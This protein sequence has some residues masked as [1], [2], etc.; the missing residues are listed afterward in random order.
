MSQTY[1]KAQ[2]V[3][4]AL[5]VAV[6]LGPFFT[7]AIAGS[8]LG[9]SA[10]RVHSSVQMLITARLAT[11]NTREGIHV[12]KSRLLDLVIYGV[13]YVFPPIIGGPSRG[14]P[15]ATALPEIGRA[16]TANDEAA[17]VW[18]DSKGVGRG[19]A[20]APLHSCVTTASQSDEALY[21]ILMAVDVLRIGGARERE[22]AIQFLRSHL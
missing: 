12:S 11:G 7:Y 8:Q 21:R 14:I 10:S 15:T 9:L 17:F 18:P 22:M 5:K 2:D 16:L 20:L 6:S 1:L 13:P 3:V 19:S 4:V